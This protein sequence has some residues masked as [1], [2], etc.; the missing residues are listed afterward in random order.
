MSIVGRLRVSVVL[1]GVGQYRRKLASFTFEPVRVDRLSSG[2]DQLFKQVG[3][4]TKGQDRLA[5]VGDVFERDAEHV[6]TR[7]AVT[8]VSAH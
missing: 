6:L 8:R 4:G 7:S 2:L 1:R 5:I 3:L